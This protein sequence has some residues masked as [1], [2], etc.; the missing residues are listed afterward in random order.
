MYKN[1]LE[2]VKSPQCT[3]EACDLALAFGEF[4]DF[5]SEALQA[6]IMDIFNFHIDMLSGEFSTS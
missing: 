6:S 2:T 1:F 5:S 3:I 4:E